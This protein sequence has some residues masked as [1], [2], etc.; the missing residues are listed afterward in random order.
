ME[1][2]F[3]SMVLDFS[4]SHCWWHLFCQL[5][6]RFYV[7]E[8]DLTL[9][10]FQTTRI[11]FSPTFFFLSFSPFLFLVFL[12]VPIFF[13]HG[14]HTVH[15]WNPGY[16]YFFLTS[17]YSFSHAAHIYHLHLLSPQFPSLHWHYYRLPAFTASPKTYNEG[18]F[19]AL[20]APVK[21]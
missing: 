21:L 12:F 10:R 19:P 6:F 14:E 20:G 1:G 16:I 8:Q 17:R 15:S 3:L 13:V 2:L 4:Y 7:F 11:L 9:S 18:N 5:W